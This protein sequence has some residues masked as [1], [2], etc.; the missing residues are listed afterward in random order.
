MFGRTVTAMLQSI[1]VERINI[2]SEGTEFGVVRDLAVA[3]VG[4]CCSL[5]ASV[6]ADIASK[7]V[8]VL[9]IDAPPLS[10]D[11]LELTPARDGGERPAR[12]FSEL[13]N[14]EAGNWR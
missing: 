3:G 7:R 5:E 11:V 14:A 2:V 6:S 12:L 4:L 1:G 10:A 13:L 8:T 9:D